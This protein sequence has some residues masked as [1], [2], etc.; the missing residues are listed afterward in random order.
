MLKH[1][2]L[3]WKAR[4]IGNK[5]AE[6]VNVMRAVKKSYGSFCQH[7]FFCTKK[8]NLLK[9]TTSYSLPFWAKIYRKYSK[10]ESKYEKIIVYSISFAV[11]GKYVEIFILIVS[12]VKYGKYAKNWKKLIAVLNFCFED[13]LQFQNITNMPKVLLNEGRLPWKNFFGSL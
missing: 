1:G 10:K 7:T 2:L 11:N 6:E 5:F 12:Q 9:W 3:F 8:K 13:D 4:F